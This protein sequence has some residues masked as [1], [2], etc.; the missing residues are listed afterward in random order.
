M[1]VLVTRASEDAERTARKLAALGH[2]PLIAPLLRIVPTGN[3]VPDVLYDAVVVTSAHAAKASALHVASTIPVFAVGERTA[4]ALRAAGFVSV[5]AAKGDAGSLSLLI[6]KRFRLPC[7]LLHVAGRHRKEEPEASLRADGFD[8]IAWEAYEAEAVE[9]LPDPA[10][11]AF[12]SSQI[13][14]V[15][16]YSR[17]SADLFVRLADQVGLRA[18]ILE[19][20]H[21]CLSADVAVPLQ[22]AGAC[23]RVADQPNEEALLELLP[24]LS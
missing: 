12:Q 2:E 19:C 3:S 10:V 13:G 1:R 22:A 24:S 17:R 6:R 4:N 20:P 18:A 21:L 14:A 8:V 7:T 23:T 9:S 11:E 5:M 16:H 15:L